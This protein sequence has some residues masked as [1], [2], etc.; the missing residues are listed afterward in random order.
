MKRKKEKLNIV[1]RCED[2]LPF[3]ASIYSRLNEKGK[4]EVI[5]KLAELGKILDKQS[6]AA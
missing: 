1:S 5:N 6:K 2:L 4:K 3:Y